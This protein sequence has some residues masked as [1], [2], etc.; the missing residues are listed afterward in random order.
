[1]DLTTLLL[2]LVIAILCAG[3]ATVLLP[4]RVPGKGIGLIIIGL[5]GVFVGQWV[6]DLLQETYGLSLAVFE[7]EL[8]GVPIL[9]SI[10]GSLLV[11]YVVT[12]LLRWGYGNR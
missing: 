1:M 6:V 11:L 7:Y 2:Q 4:R 8:E 5:I 3:M 12:A 10:L 9:P